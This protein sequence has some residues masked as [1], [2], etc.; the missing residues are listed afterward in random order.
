MKRILSIMLLIVV[1]L[2]GL[3]A[4]SGDTDREIP[5]TE[6]I[7]AGKIINIYEQSLLVAGENDYDLFVVN[8][9]S[10]ETIFFDDE[11]KR[12]EFA[13]LVAGQTI[14]IGFSGEIL[15]S[16]PA[17]L[18]GP[19]FIKIVS[20]GD[21][22]VGL[23]TKVIDDLWNTDEGLNSGVEIL[24]FD[25]TDTTN[26]SESEKQALAYVVGNAYELQG[27]IGTYEELIDQGYIDPDNL[28]FEKGLL[29]KLEVKEMTEDGFTFDASKWRGGDGAY[30]FIDCVAKKSGDGWTY[31]IGS[32]AIS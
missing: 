14:E 30:F 1:L 16:Y 22:L 13:S 11:D 12:I 19:E 3:T 2:I 21:D 29:F 32:E 23:Y 4:C 20:E 15:E 8:I 25:L 10:N 6:A 27:M 17:Q 26:L 18:A 28:Y 31:K 5:K 24:A 7:M 9:D